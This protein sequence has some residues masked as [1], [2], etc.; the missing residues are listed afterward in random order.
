MHAQDLFLTFMFLIVGIGFY[1]AF[2]MDSSN[3]L[4]VR[5]V[6]LGP[7][8]FGMFAI[9]IIVRGY[10]PSLILTA[11][12]AVVAP[13]YALVASRF[14]CKPWLDIKVKGCRV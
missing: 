10:T 6:V 11:F 13:M 5:L 4:W 12:A 8:I 2:K 7:A 1:C 3:P 9:V 14:S